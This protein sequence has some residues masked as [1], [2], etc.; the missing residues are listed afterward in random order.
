MNDCLV[1]QRFRIDQVATYA[2]IAISKIQT[3]VKM[4]LAT[5]YGNELHLQIARDSDFRDMLLL[6][7]FDLEKRMYPGVPF[8]SKR[9]DQQV[10]GQILMGVCI[11]HC[12]TN[13]TENIYKAA[14]RIHPGAH[15]QQVEKVADQP[16][17]FG[18]PAVG[19]RG[20]DTYILRTAETMERQFQQRQH[21]HIQ[22]GS[23]RP[24]QNANALAQFTRQLELVVIFL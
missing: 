5:G 8:R 17:C 23:V 3:Q 13:P 1:K 9:I 15:D 10:E 20:A 24:C 19:D 12:L 4:S 21:H 22:R 7:T 2:V 18:L 6:S 11:Q 14:R 16:L